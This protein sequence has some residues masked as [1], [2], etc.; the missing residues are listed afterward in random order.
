MSNIIREWR[1]TNTDDMTKEEL[2]EALSEM[3]QLLQE[4]MNQSTQ[5]IQYLLRLVR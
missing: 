4:A 1:G 2:V 3:Q 5:D